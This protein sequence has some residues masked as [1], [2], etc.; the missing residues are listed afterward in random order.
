VAM[1]PQQRACRAHLEELPGNL[2]ERNEPH[3]V[4]DS[5]DTR[6]TFCVMWPRIAA[7]RAYIA[8]VAPVPHDA[9]LVTKPLLRKP[10]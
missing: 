9:G 10:R 4:V 3:G 7:S 6:C 2:V 5:R 8:D 1:P